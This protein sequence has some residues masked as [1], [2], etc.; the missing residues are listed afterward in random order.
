VHRF[1]QL[2]Q[3]P[4]THDALV[5]MGQLMFASHESYSA[6]GL[7]SDGT[8]LLVQMVRDRGPQRGMYGAKITGGGSGGTVCVLGRADADPQIDEI[9]RDYRKRTG[10]ETYVFR[11]SSPG[12]W[13]T[14]VSQVI[15]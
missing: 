3:G 13:A 5:E 7:D 8:D 10:R 12:A 9:A 11:G 6:C 1:R 14:D 4:I 2:L 15:I